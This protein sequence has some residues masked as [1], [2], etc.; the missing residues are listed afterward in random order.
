MSWRLI[1]ESSKPEMISDRVNR[2]CI[3]MSEWYITTHA[4]WTNSSGL[5][6]SHIAIAACDRNEIPYN[7]R[8][9]REC[10][11][12]IKSKYP[13]SMECMERGKSLRIYSFWMC[14][15]GFVLHISSWIS[16]YT[17]CIRFKKK[18]MLSDVLRQFNSYEKNHSRTLRS[19]R[20][21][22]DMKM[23]HSIS[24]IHTICFSANKYSIID[25]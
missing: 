9:K 4:K 21:Q 1:R 6:Q 16:P 3:T 19:N 20:S 7:I 22:F 23:R 18:R 2:L 14:V 12:H 13:C 24:N 15:N 5:M 8:Y 17:I 10:C 11:T 25:Q